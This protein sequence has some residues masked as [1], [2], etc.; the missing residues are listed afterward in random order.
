M[1]RCTDPNHKSYKNYGGRGIG[2]CNR[3]MEFKNFFNDM[4]HPPKGF[5]IERIDNNGDYTPKN[6]KWASMTVN[7]RNK[8]NNHVVEINGTRKCIAEWSEEYDA[9]PIK[10]RQR[11]VEYGWSPIRALTEP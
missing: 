7:L 2:I 4:G 1:E 5:T 9:N 3:W 11:L 6:C 10:V 8:R